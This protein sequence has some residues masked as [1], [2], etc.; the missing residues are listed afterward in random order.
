MRW[1]LEQASQPRGAGKARK[2]GQT[3]FSRCDFRVHVRV[4]FR[5]D[6]QRYRLCYL[7]T[8]WCSENQPKAGITECRGD[9]GGVPHGAVGPDADR[10]L[11][12]LCQLP[13]YRNRAQAPEVVPARPFF[14]NIFDFQSRNFQI[15]DF[16]S[17]FLLINP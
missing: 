11:P 13:W 1:R 16:K 9:S 4:D 14:S 7:T 15:F 8:V 5:V 3:G 2:G 17:N 12:H 6:F 10:G